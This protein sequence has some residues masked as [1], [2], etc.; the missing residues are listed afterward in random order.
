MLIVSGPPDS[1][2]E[3]IDPLNTDFRQQIIAAQDRDIHK[4][5]APASLIIFKDTHQFYP[6]D[7]LDAINQ[8]TGVS[9]APQNHANITHR[10]SFTRCRYIQVTESF[11]EKPIIQGHLFQLGDDDFGRPPQT[12]WVR[13][14]MQTGPEF[15]PEGLKNSF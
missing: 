13:Q 10:S 4:L 12:I 5:L 9:A 6:A 1:D 14:L 11:H 2:Y 8:H 3:T 7:Y 15:R